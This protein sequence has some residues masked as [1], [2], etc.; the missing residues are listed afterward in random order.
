[1]SSREDDE[2]A[3]MPQS[4]A[5]ALVALRR[6]ACSHDAPGDRTGVGS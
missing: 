5:S 6:P 2:V 3:Q 4:S 1:V